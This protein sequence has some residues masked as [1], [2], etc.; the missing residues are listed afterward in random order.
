MTYNVSPGGL[1]VRT[2]DSVERGA[3]V[4]V[5][6]RPP[7]SPSTV[8]LTGRVAWVAAPSSQGR[9]MSPPGFGVE[10][11]R[12]HCLESECQRYQVALS[13][14]A[15]EAATEFPFLCVSTAQ[16]EATPPTSVVSE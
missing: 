3:H 1:F 16:A 7:A 4:D 10:I 12:E 5:K 6:F 14:A 8:E 2:Y 9:V 15:D 11:L 13:I